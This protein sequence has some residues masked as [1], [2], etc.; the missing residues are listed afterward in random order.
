MS[1]FLEPKYSTPKIFPFTPFSDTNLKFSGLTP[2]KFSFE[3]VPSLCSGIF[4]EE[5]SNLILD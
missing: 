3:F 2:K 5:S 1:I 4:K